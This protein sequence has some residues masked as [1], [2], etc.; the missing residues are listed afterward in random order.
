MTEKLTLIGILQR[1]KEFDDD[2]SDLS[3]DQFKELVGEILPE[4]VDDCK[5]FLTKLSVEIQAIKSEIDDLQKAKKSLETSE[6]NFK[7]YLAYALE[8]TGTQK[9]QG[10]RH[11]LSLQTRKTVQ[12]KTF[13]VTSQHYIEL[14]MLLPDTIKR[15][16]S[17]SK[18]NFKQLCEKHPEILEKYGE[19][20]V[21]SFTTFRVRRD[22]S[23]D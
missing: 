2:V 1:M 14:N 4:K 22:L 18:A 19:E 17:I 16:Y 11:T 10:L 3:F 21:N 7:K 15:E 23:N 9:L 20:T 13:D 12:P 6:A 5:K 8:S